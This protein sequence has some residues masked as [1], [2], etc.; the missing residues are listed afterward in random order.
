MTNRDL[1]LQDD[2]SSLRLGLRLWDRSASLPAGYNLSK[3]QN[4]VLARSCS[5][6]SDGALEGQG[7]GQLV[8]VLLKEVSCS[9]ATKGL[10]IP[11]DHSLLT[12][13]LRDYH[14]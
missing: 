7:G 10:R 12:V 6:S 2:P 5:S 8:Q 3:V 1:E 11:W 9:W 13:A 4:I 14:R